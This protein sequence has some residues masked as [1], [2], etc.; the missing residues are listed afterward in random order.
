MTR[1]NL[2]DWAVIALAMGGTMLVTSV[3][4]PMVQ[5]FIMGTVAGLSWV[6][7]RRSQRMEL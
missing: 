5:G 1:R 2:Y 4:S 6:A 3:D 7:G